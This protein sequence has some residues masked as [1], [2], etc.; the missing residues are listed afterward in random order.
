MK[1]LVSAYTGLGNFILRTPMLHT[2]KRIVPNT[3]ISLITGTS[4]LDNVSSAAKELPW[5][6]STYS[7]SQTA[8]WKEKLRFFRKLKN[9]NYDVVFLPFDSM[10]RF[11][12]VGSYLANI[13]LRVLHTSFT[14]RSYLSVCKR[15]CKML[16]M[17]KTVHVPILQGRHEI[18]LN[19]DL[20]EAYLNEPLEREYTTLFPFCRDESVISRFGL[21]RNRFFVL[22]MA[23]RHGAPTPK[24]W[25]PKKFR[26]LIEQLYEK[27][28]KLKL[29]TV[30]SKSDYEEGIKQMIAGLPYVVNTAGE[31]SLNDLAN[32]LTDCRIAIVHDSGTM[33]VA[34]ALDVPLIALY[35]P[36][37]HTRTRPL[38]TN[39]HLIF[40]KNKYLASMYN[41]RYSEEELCALTKQYECMDAINIDDVMNQVDVF[42]RSR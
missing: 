39:S 18:D 28:P 30:G 38:G 11:L 42:D 6:H 22:Q 13:P 41:L 14:T 26:V 21:E 34:N 2:L 3:T 5:I 12:I 37:D 8:P 32:L 24:V 36:T 9:E 7:L 23:A 40:S 17:P 33:H 10:P 1:I 16:V 15:A 35:G 29:V 31:T 20:L 25:D 19:Y 4:S 27:Y